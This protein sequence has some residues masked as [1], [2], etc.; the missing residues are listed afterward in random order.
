MTAAVD[1]LLQQVREPNTPFLSPER[2]AGVL[3]MD[4]Q[5]LAGIAGVH[6]N[7]VRG[8]PRSARL[9]EGMRDI[10]RVVSATEGLGMSL[11]DA[12]YWISNRPLREFANKTALELIREG[13]TDAV[14]LYL[15]SIE[16]G[17]V[18]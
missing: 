18:G 14:L 9:Q 3:H 1:V 13:Q 15:D 10:L 5:T 16:S 4:L 17:Y 7:T 12:L 8:N 6:R 2:F 11:D